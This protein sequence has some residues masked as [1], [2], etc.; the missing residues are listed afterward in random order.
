M[1]LFEESS[2]VPLLIVAPGYRRGV[3]SAA[4]VSH[5]D[6]FPT[7]AELC[8]IQT[9]DGL[10]G[11]SLVPMLRDVNHQGR[12]W[13][14]TQVTRGNARGNGARN[15]PN[16]NSEDGGFFGYSLRTP[17]WRYTEWAGGD[18]GRELYDHE[19]D[20][21]EQT[22]LAEAPELRETVAELSAVMTEAVRTTYP[23]SGQTPKVQQGLWAPV[24]VDP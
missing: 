10:Q 22:N 3:A 6:I 24:F 9:P 17:R 15:R 20:P 1:S 16:A 13:A 5:V 7:L 23:A 8:N 11:Q 21:A 4:P 12:G 14:L 18:E 19:A 2:R